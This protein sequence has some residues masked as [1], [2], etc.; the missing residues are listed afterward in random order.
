[1]TFALPGG[2]I[3]AIEVAPRT[4]EFTMTST[5]ANTR[6]ANPFIPTER[7]WHWIVLCAT[8]ILLYACFHFVV[9]A[10]SD[11]IRYVIGFKQWI[12]QGIEPFNYEMSF[13]YYWALRPFAAW[14][15]PSAVPAVSNGLSAVAGTLA[16]LPLYELFR[17]LVGA[18]VAFFS[19]LFFLLSPAYWTITRYGHPVI[20]ALFFFFCALAAFEH[21]MS[22]HHGRLAPAAGTRRVTGGLVLAMLCAL[23]ALALRGDLLLAF[24]APL[25][26]LLY[27][28]SSRRWMIRTTGIF[29]GGVLAGTMALRWLVLGYVLNPAGGTLRYHLT[30]RIGDLQSMISHSIKNAAL[31]F[32]SLLPLVAVGIGI[33]VLWLIYRRQWRLLTLVSL[34]SLPPLLAFLPFGGMDYIRLTLPALPP[35]FLALVVWID[36]A[37]PVRFRVLAPILLLIVSHLTPGLTRPVLT[38]AYQ[39][40]ATYNDQPVTSIPLEPLVVGFMID[41][42]FFD[43][44]QRL[45]QDVTS[46]GEP[47]VAILATSTQMPWYLYELIVMQNA[48]CR[49][50]SVAGSRDVRMCT[51]GERA[52]YTVDVDAAAGQRALEHM[53]GDAAWTTTRFHVNPFMADVPPGDTL[54]SQSEV[55][56]LLADAPSFVTNFR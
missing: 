47:P 49:L 1:M 27:R 36:H 34:W 3:F 18:R 53:A 4:G 17:S 42:D 39:F 8:A 9:L 5:P 11:Q 25:G 35:L 38:R 41:R 16:L 13:A 54:R 43:A 14:L 15:P 33:A 24:L 10:D 22:A 12:E 51:V 30:E 26:L 52:F 2:M 40:K 44:Q 46:A 31:L 50:I 29:Y 37:T 19:T 23:A 56:Q 32:F 45:A 48:D 55:A 6:P 21:A 20:P 7:A 28:P